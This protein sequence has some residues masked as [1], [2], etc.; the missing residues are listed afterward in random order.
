MLAELS[1][2]HASYLVQDVRMFTYLVYFSAYCVPI[3]HV[4]QRQEVQRLNASVNS[5][6]AQSPPPPGYCRAFVRLVSPGG[7]AF[8]NFALPRGRAFA[9]PRSICELL[10]LTQL[11]IR[12]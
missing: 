6:C 3:T 9:N 10:T 8:A 2:P 4:R 7:G 11:P 12:I 1:F 5:S